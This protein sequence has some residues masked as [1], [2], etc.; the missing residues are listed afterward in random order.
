MWHR[1]PAGYG[2]AAMLTM[3]VGHSDEIDPLE[4]VEAAIAQCRT[5][6]GP[7][8]PQAALL[9]A[10]F[11]S[12]APGVVEA[13]RAAFPGIHVMGSTSAAEVSSVSGFAEDS[14]SLAVFGVDGIDATTGFSP[15]LGDDV[16]ATCAAAAR[17]ALEATDRSPR[18]AIVLADAF[19]ADPQRTAEAISRALPDGVVVVGGGSARAEIGISVPTYQFCDDRVAEDGVALLLFSGDLAVSAAVGTGWRPL[20]ARGTVTAARGG[21][22][23]SIDGRPANEFLAP[24]IDVFGPAAFGN[25]LT[26]IKPD[27]ERTY[28][29]ALIS[30]DPATGAVRVH[31]GVPVGAVV[32]LTTAGTDDILDGTRDAVTRALHDFPPG[33]RPEAALMFSCMVRKYLLGTR[34]KVEAE[35]AREALGP[36]VSL[37]GLYCAGEIGPVGGGSSRFLNETFVTVLLGT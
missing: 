32:Q 21:L 17:E 8:E 18:L 30:S 7:V 1:V 34:T 9:V 33:A 29:R 31:G 19:A 22:I 27:A 3:A 36:S 26:V 25:P 6:L 10:A 16:D 35:M 37:A 24:Y 13:V 12:F 2:E 23:E 28:L 14:I 11:G 15:G 4:A 20:G 5:S